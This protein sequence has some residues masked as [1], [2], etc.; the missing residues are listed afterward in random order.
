MT[1]NMKRL[2]LSMS[3]PVAFAVG[4]YAQKVSGYV[5][6]SDNKPVADAVISSQGC[7]SVR[8]GNDGS[9]TI[10]GVKEGQ[11]LNVWHDG[12]F[13]KV[14]YL[15]DN[16]ANDLHV[17]LIEE[18]RSRYNE[19]QITPFGDVQGNPVAGSNA[20]L[21]RKDF[22]LGAL[23]VDNALKGE[24]AGLQ[25]TN[26]SGMTGEGAMMQFRGVRSLVADNAPLVV[27]NG[28]PYMP[29]A[30]I[31][32]IIKG[33]SRSW[34]Q[35]FNG[36]DI[37]N[38]TLLKGADAAAYG[39]M[40]SNGVLMI[41]TDQASTTN[42]NTR[43]S[44]SAIAGMNW[45]KKRIPLMNASQYKSYLSDIGLT[46]YANQE[47][48]FK[49][50]TFLSNPDANMSY[51][52]QYDTNWQDE[53]YHNSSTMD[54]LFRVEGGD[55]IAKYNI[56][57]GYMGD[58]GTIRETFTD[59]YNAQINASVLVSKQFEIRA[60]INMAYLKGQ[61]QEQ[62]MSLETNPMLA[63]YR[64]APLLNP[65]QSDMYGNLI[66]R[67]ASYR[68]GAIENSDFWVSN[69]V[70]MVNT[71]TATN[72]QYDMNAKIHLIYSPIRNLTLNGIVGMYYNYNQEETFVPG[73]D[74]EDIVPQ[75]DQYGE[76]K[77]SVRVGTNHTFNLFFN[78]NGAYKLNLGER[79]KLNFNLGWQSL[80]TNYEYDAA[81]G[82]NTGN[83]FYKTMGKTQ[84][85]GKYFT[86]Y[87]NK[88]NWM[89]IFAHAD[90]TYNNLVKVGMTASLDGSSA[91]GKDASRM[92]FYPAFDA[93]L[94]A[95]NLPG[96]SQASWLD[97]LNV[98]ANLTF[99]GNSR[100]ESKFGKYYYTSQPYQT[101][102]GIV[103]ANVPNT[104]LEPERDRTF[105]V[106]LETSLLRNRLQIGLGYYN[107]QATNVL[108]TGTRSSALG[109]SLYYNNDAELESKGLEL[110]LSVMPI[111]LKDF[112]WMVG[113]N[114]TTL[115]NRVKSLGTLN[116]LVTTL[117]D[118]AQVITR[119]GEDPYA[120]Y[121]YRSL[122]VFSTTAEAEKAHYDAETDTYSNLTANGQQF[123]AGDVHYLDKNNDGVIDD[124]DREVLGSATPDFFGSFFTRFEYKNFALDMTFAY[125]VGNKAYNAVRRVTESGNN[126]TNQSTALLRRWSMEGQQTDIP[127]VRFN[128]LVGNNAFSDRW[129]EDASYLKLRDVT[130]SYTW[131]KPLFNFLQGGT[132]FV[133]GQNLICFTKYLGLDPEFSYS[134]SSLMQGVDYA[135]ATAPRAF[136]VG[137]NLRF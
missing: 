19:T 71:L 95:K 122:G 55:N 106:G 57:L 62:G 60:N 24:L 28:V 126:F 137:V 50:F 51:L 83:D 3:L 134:Y 104:T 108:M 16:Q 105:N 86:G 110:S 90:Y 2:I 69:P 121:G 75:F 98:Y 77:N 112:R 102:A 72:R 78:V 91:T 136:K 118:D 129:I 12:F 84:T 47:A 8:S 44:F 1:N 114:I 14:V 79:H 36:Q 43:I 116:E 42:M 54:Y 88:W 97:K 107:T 9:F 82:R 89:N 81:F 30:N 87:N 61:Y 13:N 21:N 7:E 58:N 27:I 31:S 124:N 66:S 131:N 65:M 39:S 41:E 25:V 70:S 48:F 59:R 33:Y 133:T 117:D 49:D 113:G 15:L 76:I 46:Y 63:A 67:Y 80:L 125:S 132:V 56:S 68:F 5:F 123:Q 6:T 73:I 103:R 23:S 20:N 10:N 135:K 92:F 93:V 100:Y 4:I 40:G 26:K 18:N 85:I 52:Y 22:A 128:D 101:I 38:I 29:D 109:T 99:T 35:A 119:V 94:M 120:F 111:A 17:Y 130:L 11:P 96:L 127:R 37:R 53:I 115:K 32:Q 74:N 34:F 64:R 45:N